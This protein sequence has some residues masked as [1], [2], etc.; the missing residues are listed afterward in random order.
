VNN[1]ASNRR[2]III[3]GLLGIFALTLVFH[4]GRIML[5]PG[6]E[7][8][9]PIADVQIERGPILDRNGR[10]LAIQTE[11]PTVTVWTP[12]VEDP[13]ATAEQLSR[14]LDLDYDALLSNLQLENRDVIVKRT[15]SPGEAEIIELLKQQGELRGVNLRRDFGRIYPEGR[16]ASHVLGFTGTDNRGLEGIELTQNAI[17]S[18]GNRAGSREYGSQIVLT[19]DVV[20]Q[21]TM[22][23]IADRLMETHNPDSVMIMV[24]DAPTGEFLSYVSVP[25]FDPN[26]FSQYDENARRNRPIQM[27]YEPGS[28]FKVFSLA[29]MIHLGGVN[30]A[31]RFDTTGGYTSDQIDIPITDLGNYGVLSPGGIIKYSSN[32]GAA[33]ASDTVDRESFYYMLRQFGFGQTTELELNGEERGLLAPENRWSGRTKPTIAIGQEIGVTAVQM[34]QAATALAN[35]G[36]MLR[37]HLIK[38]IVDASGSVIREF[39]REPVREVL[40]RPVADQILEYMR[41]ASEANGTGRRA[42]IEGVNISVK[43]GTAEVIDPATGRYSDELFVASTLAIFPTEDPRLI[44]YVVIQHPRG[45]S[46]LGGVIAAPVVREIA[47]FLIPYLQI[48]TGEQ[49]ITDLPQNVE[50]FEPALPEIGTTIP[51]F[52]GLPLKTVIPLYGRDDLYVQIRGS[53]WVVSQDPLPGSPY[54]EGMELTLYLADDEAP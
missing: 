35:D 19:I 4:Y 44:I 27:A 13:E 25:D 34:V 24:L 11:L 39:Q 41:G 51:D 23:Q 36:V 47:E 2:I 50:I 26:E 38:R 29:S 22:E 54:R 16:T 9:D 49:R 5:T 17:L 42:A 15:I 30:D 14:I 43:T 10:L 52:T 33:Y 40:R 3:A 28:V 31:S 8:S 20:I 45:E 1:A 48:N 7:G 53:G 12:Y 18:P 37:P 32:V 46:F 21:H 6:P